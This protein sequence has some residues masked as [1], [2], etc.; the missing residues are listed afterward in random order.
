MWVILL[1]CM[2]TLALFRVLVNHYN[3]QVTRYASYVS[4]YFIADQDVEKHDT[5]MTRPCRKH[6]AQCCDL[7][8]NR[9]T[10]QSTE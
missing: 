8:E 10:S 9:I 7:V 2:I 1:L 6:F 3:I 5:V 4:S